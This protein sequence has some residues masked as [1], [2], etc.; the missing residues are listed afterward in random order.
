MLLWHPLQRLI[1]QNIPNFDVIGVSVF[2]WVCPRALLTSTASA[3]LLTSWAMQY[4]IPRFP[5]VEETKGPAEDTQ[6]HPSGFQIT[7]LPER[8][9]QWW[10]VSPKRVIC[11]R[12]IKSCD[13]VREERDCS[14]LGHNFISWE[15]QTTLGM[16]HNELKQET[17]Q[18]SS[19]KNNIFRALT[20][21]DNLGT[22]QFHFWGCW[23]TLK[24]TF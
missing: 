9:V 7:S 16:L 12:K 11:G 20:S 8:D 13:I 6:I 3:S 5:K 14:C 19:T 22:T 24:L 2:G 4:I 21:S 23:S 17:G 10:P 15:M 18:Q 1:T